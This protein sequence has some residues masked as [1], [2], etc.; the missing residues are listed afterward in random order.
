M[1]IREAAVLSVL[2]SCGGGSTGTGTGTGA[3]TGSYDGTWNVSMLSGEAT[4]PNSQIVVANDKV[5]GAITKD[6]EG[7]TIGGCLYEKARVEVSLEF[8]GNDVS[9]AL[10]SR[11]KIT[12]CSTT[13]DDS[14][15]LPVKG[16]R[17]SAGGGADGDWEITL[18]ADRGACAPYCADDVVF[19]VKVTGQS[20]QAWSKEER[21]RG[22]TPPLNATV[23]GGSANG[24]GRRDLTFTATK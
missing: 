15:P 2:V 16:T 23:S 21:A 6:I 8:V 22:A 10:T 5:T 7:Q 9:G 12:G 13:F 3:V 4:G 20:A 24:A 1:R 19:V 18:S 14:Q 17:T 11:Y